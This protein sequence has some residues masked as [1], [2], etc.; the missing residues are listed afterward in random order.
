MEA[1]VFLSKGLDKTFTTMK[2]P[3]NRIRLIETDLCA[4]TITLTV[5]GALRNM[6][7]GIDDGFRPQTSSFKI[8]V[9]ADTVVRTITQLLTLI[10]E[11]LLTHCCL[12]FIEDSSYY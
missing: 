3:Y 7:D 8:V 6:I 2:L 4:R 5:F 10:T 11:H 12:D 9:R 1:E